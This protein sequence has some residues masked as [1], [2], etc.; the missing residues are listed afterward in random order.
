MSAKVLPTKAT[1]AEAQAVAKAKAQGV[2]PYRIRIGGQ[3]LIVRAPDADE[4][5]FIL[6]K[7][8]EARANKRGSSDA[9]RSFLALVCLYPTGDELKALLKRKPMIATACL[10]K[11]LELAGLEDASELEK[12]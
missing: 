8:A 10:D 1:E 6:D 12:L 7:K 9:D 3:A 5:D 11:L 4:A 2:E